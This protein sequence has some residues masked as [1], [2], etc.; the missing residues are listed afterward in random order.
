MKQRQVRRKGAT[1]NAAGNRAEEWFESHLTSQG[2]EF[3]HEPKIAGRSK[4]IDYRITLPSGGVVWCEVK[5]LSAR[6]KLPDRGVGSFAADPCKPIREEIRDASRK[7]REYKGEPCVL[8]LKADD[9]GELANTE[10]SMMFAAMLGDLAMT[11]SAGN[12]SPVFTANG[13]MLRP[14]GGDPQNTTISAV[15][16]VSNYEIRNPE[17]DRVLAERR[18]NHCLPTRKGS[19]H[20]DFGAGWRSALKLR[21]RSREAWDMPSECA[22]SKIRLPGIL[23]RSPF[24]AVNSTNDTDSY[25]TMLAQHTEPLSLPSPGDTR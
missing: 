1:S 8:V 5:S 16:V 20:G 10:P 23:C 19:T 7:F 3:K 14:K 22:S 12:W 21:A 13:A 17:F 6:Y 15:A 25:S 4:M 2:L 9:N 11:G 24:S 18:A